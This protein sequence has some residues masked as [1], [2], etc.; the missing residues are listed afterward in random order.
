[1]EQEVLDDFWETISFIL[2]ILSIAGLLLAPLYFARL[3]FRYVES[4]VQVKNA[5]KEEEERER[6]RLHLERNP[7]PRPNHL[8]Q[9]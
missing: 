5:L 9:R 4:V 8:H 6:E 2:S 1:M 3:A 7:P